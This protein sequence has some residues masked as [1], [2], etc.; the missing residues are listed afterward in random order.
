MITSLPVFLLVL[1]LILAEL[2][3]AIFFLI[4]LVSWVFALGDRHCDD[5]A[6]FSS[7]MKRSLLWAILCPG[8]T[9]LLPVVLAI[10]AVAAWREHGARALGAV[11]ALPRLP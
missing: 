5:I 4:G 9:L 1:L 2:L 10:F 11:R 6:Y 7:M 3:C 8:L